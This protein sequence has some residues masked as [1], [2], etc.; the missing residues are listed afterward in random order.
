MGWTSFRWA[1][2]HRAARESTVET[3]WKGGI[4]VDESTLSALLIFLAAVVGLVTE[5]ARRRRDR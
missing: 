3:F 4:A 2:S 1:V 5:L